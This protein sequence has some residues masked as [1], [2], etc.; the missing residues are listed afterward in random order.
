MCVSRSLR[1]L[2]LLSL[3]AASVTAYRI[4]AQ[5]QRGYGSGLGLSATGNGWMSG[6]SMGGMGGLGGKGGKSAGGKGGGGMDAK[7]AQA[8][9]ELARLLA[10]SASEGR[11]AKSSQETLDA[12]ANAI[13]TL[14]EGNPNP[15]PVN[16]ELIDGCWKLLY[17]SSPGTNR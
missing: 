1:L 10:I 5:A 15:E 14:E 11:G 2:C 13:L 12:I 16:S 7:T 6:V 8:E 17:T 4:A 9:E 3:L